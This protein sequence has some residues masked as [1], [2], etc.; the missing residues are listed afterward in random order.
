M[1]KK[2]LR[3]SIFNADYNVAKSNFNKTSKVKLKTI[4]LI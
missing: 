2:V 4:Y 3:P 1:N